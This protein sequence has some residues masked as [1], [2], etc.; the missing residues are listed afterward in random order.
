MP[1]SANPGKKK[2]GMGLVNSDKI[3]CSNTLDCGGKLKFLSGAEFS[4]ELATSVKEIL[5]IDSIGQKHPV[6]RFEVL[7]ES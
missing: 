7:K 4:A 2:F 6:G 5:D 1:P 3:A